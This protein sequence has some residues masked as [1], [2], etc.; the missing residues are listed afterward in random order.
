MTG[1]MLAAAL[2]YA[3]RGTPVFPCNNDKAPY[4]ANGFKDATID[5]ATIRDWWERWPDALIGAPV[6]EGV[7]CLDL[8]PRAGGELSALFADPP[9]TRTVWSGRGDGGRHFY[10]VRP[11]G[12]FT[13]T[14]LPDGWDLR[15]GGKAYLIMPPSPH[16]ATGKAYVWDT[17]ADAP[18]AALPAD[19]AAL[20]TRPDVPA[21]QV[22]TTGAAQYGGTDQGTPYALAALRNECEVLA[23]MA[24]GSGRNE[25]LNRA[26]FNLGQLVGGG[27]LEETHAVDRLYDAAI[28]CGLS[29]REIVGYTG[30][31]GT[32]WSGLNGGKKSPRNTPP[33]E[34]SLGASPGLETPTTADDR[35][36]T[37]GPTL[38]GKRIVV[39]KASEYETRPIVWLWDGLVPMGALSVFAGREGIG[40]STALY[41]A[42]AQITRGELPGEHYGAP[43]DVFVCATEDGW[44]DTIK[45]RLMA[46]GAD[47]DRVHSVFTDT[48]SLTFPAD[49]G[50]LTETLRDHRPAAVIF[51][52]L[53]SRMS[54]GIDT[55][56]DADVRSALE[57]L[58][59]MAEEC[60]VAVI[61]LMHVNKSTSGDATNRLMGSRAFASVPRSVVMFT[62]DRN[63]DFARMG[64]TKANLTATSKGT[65]RLRITSMVVDR[66][67]HAGRMR[68]V[69]AS[70]VEWLA[71]DAVS[72]DDAM[73]AA[74]ETSVA[75][76][77]TDE[78]TDWL[79]GY[80][81]DKN[82]EAT[83][84]DVL[85]AARP[86]GHLIDALN[87]AKRRLGVVSTNTRT[88][89]RKALW[90][91][92]PTVNHA[93]IVRDSLESHN[94]TDAQ[95][96]TTETN[97]HPP[98]HAGT[99]L[100]LSKESAHEWRTTAPAGPAD[101]FG[102][103]S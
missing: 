103:A 93:P 100:W 14:G 1:P 22:R 61:G 36:K 54:G 47:L 24:P 99:R 77:A 30:N 43:R 58:K 3:A 49:I 75:R 95:L 44:S 85:K 98:T 12:V 91:L 94:R 45:P 96:E 16:P 57:P 17:T 37:N 87:R 73:E 39:K 97:H 29:H 7:V 66:V 88:M 81:T 65:K 42:A 38:G 20:L 23:R 8:D 80:L 52:P 5:Q 46:N 51:D 69:T 72:I 63:E 2:D 41:W 34:A 55:H 92:P 32:L 40:K 11:D 9:A 83:K 13:S 50:I 25:A 19:V 33:R 15:D 4:T 53:M 86:E 21:H 68:D 26:A 71:D 18:L 48:G 89:P 76:N 27:E 59:A 64:C 28:T 78:A 74:G 79:H 101:A 102:V 67:M 10:W 70:K 60:D 82:G 56:K 62:K 31:A 35:T 84:E 6:P 90:S